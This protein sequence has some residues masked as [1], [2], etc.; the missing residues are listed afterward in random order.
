MVGAGCSTCGGYG[1]HH[2][3]VAHG[4]Q[5]EPEEEFEEVPELIDV[6]AEEI[7]RQQAR[8]A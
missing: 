1:G 8:D 3:P 7:A 2:D 4:W 6:L 5:A